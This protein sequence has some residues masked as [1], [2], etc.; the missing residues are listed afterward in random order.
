MVIKE[1]SAKDNQGLSDR[2]IWVYTYIYIYIYIYTPEISPSKF[3]WGRNDTSERLLNMSIEVLYVP[4]NFYTPQNKFQA[5]PLHFIM[6]HILRHE[7][8]DMQILAVG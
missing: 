8:W 2:G 4:Q 6:F 3:L 7:I 1:F 5:T